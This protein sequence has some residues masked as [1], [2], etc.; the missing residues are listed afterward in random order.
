M[1]TLANLK[2]IAVAVAAI[3][4]PVLVALLGSH[5]NAAIK[6]REVSAKFV[7][8]AVQ[9]LQK[10]PSKTDMD[11][12][13][14]TWATRVLD[15]YSGVPFDQKTREEI[16]RQ[17]P[18]PRVIDVPLEGGS[19]GVTADRI[20]D[21]VI[22]RDTQQSDLEKEL[23]GLRASNVSYH[24]I[25]GKDRVITR[26]KDED[27]V[28]FHSARFNETSIGIGLLHV[29]GAEDYTSQQIESLSQ[30]VSGIVKRRRVARSN[31]NGIAELDPTRRSDFAK[32]K[33]RVLTAAFN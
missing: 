23:Q 14:R 33:E 20:I 13:V 27:D 26:L 6:E 19:R 31:V 3:A 22:V 12:G 5:Y 11:A 9:I 16:V 17:V 18:L 2:D 21:R 24:Y 8:L 7:E 28:A 10:D 1:M 4:V 15:Q 32:I 25:V 29:S 30:L